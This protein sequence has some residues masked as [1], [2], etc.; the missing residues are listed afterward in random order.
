MKGGTVVAGMGGCLLVVG[1]AVPVTAL[2]LWPERESGTEH[3]VLER[4]LPARPG[5]NTTRAYALPQGRALNVGFEGTIVCRSFRRRPDTAQDWWEPSPSLGI[6]VQLVDAAGRT[7]LRDSTRMN[8]GS[9]TE[10]PMR[11][12]S[13]TR[14]ADLQRCRTSVT[15]DAL[16]EAQDVRV[17]AIL[18]GEDAPDSY[19]KDGRMTVTEVPNPADNP[20]FNQVAMCCGLNIPV[21]LGLL[22]LGLFLRRRRARAQ[23]PGT[24]V[25]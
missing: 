9:C 14:E 24:P 4:D 25:G 21:G 7:V 1:I 5:S 12:P 23:A 6:E 8:E 15:M 19:L 10:P 11:V 3:V 16:P 20:F 22:I 13:T 18:P 17:V 2:L